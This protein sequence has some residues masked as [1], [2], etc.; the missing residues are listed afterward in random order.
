MPAFTLRIGR[1]LNLD[2]S[3]RNG[4][5]AVLAFRNDAF[6]IALAYHLIKI[7]AVVCK[8]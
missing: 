1:I 2:P 6:Q 4:V 8:Q 5:L 7:G 3:R